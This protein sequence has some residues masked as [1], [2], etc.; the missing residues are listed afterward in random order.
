MDFK[1]D[2]SHV[3]EV[4]VDEAPSPRPDRREVV[5]AG[6]LPPEEVLSRSLSVPLRIY[7]EDRL[8]GEARVRAD[9]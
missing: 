5:W 1:E 4:H 3:F 8:E 7:L 6:F 2:H 9:R